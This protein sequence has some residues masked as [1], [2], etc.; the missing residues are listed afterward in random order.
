MDSPRG[1]EIDERKEERNEMTHQRP[2]H[3]QIASRAY[4]IFLERGREPGHDVDDWL[5]AEYELM[6]LP[7]SELAELDSPPSG[8]SKGGRRSIVELVKAAVV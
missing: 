3:Q 5:Q 8:K 4:Q 6:Q 1:D 7:L 2:T